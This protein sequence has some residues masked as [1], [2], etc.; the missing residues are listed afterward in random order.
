[1][2][3]PTTTSFALLGLLALRPWTAY[4]LVGQTQRGLRWFWPRSQ[5]HVYAQ[6]KRLVKLGF[7]E[8]EVLER[9]RRSRTRYSITPAG[10]A[11]LREWLATTPAPPLIE[12]ESFLRLFLADQAGSAELLAA[13]ESTHEQA[14]R[15]Y[16]EGRAI[17]QELVATGGPFPERLHLVAPLLVFYESFLRM[18]IEWCES[19]IAEVRGWDGTVGHG[20]SKEARER[21][22]AITQTTP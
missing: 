15:M 7:A 10:R 11:A 21:L 6:V 18:L 22:E 1:V 20:L 16:A 12:V 13:L 8:A 19:T 3:A 9:G 5:A 2:T 17:T 4:E 14:T